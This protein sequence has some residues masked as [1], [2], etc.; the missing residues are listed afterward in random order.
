VGRICKSEI[1]RYTRKVRRVNREF[2]KLRYVVRRAGCSEGENTWELGE[3]LEN[4][5]EEV[6]NWNRENP[7]MPG[8]NLAEYCEKDLP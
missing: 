2:K 5:R 1:I 7:E 8:P 6:E 4:A 3:G